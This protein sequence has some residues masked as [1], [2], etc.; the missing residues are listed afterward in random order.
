MSPPEPAG[1]GGGGVRDVATAKH[2]ATPFRVEVPE[3]DLVDLH[4]RLDATRWPDPSVGA[5][6]AQG[7]D[8]QYLRGLV[9]H[10]RHDFDWRA[11]E[12][13]INSTPMF[14]VETG[15]LRLHCA[16]TD[17]RPPGRPLL[18][19]SGWPSTW[20]EHHLVAPRLAAAGL[21]CVWASLP[22]YGFSERPTQPGMTPRRA[23]ALLVHTM[24]VL[25]HPVFAVHGTDWGMLV[26]T[27]MALDHPRSV[28]AIHLDRVPPLGDDDPR[29][30]SRAARY[31]A[32]ERA[33]QLLNGTR[34]QSL[35]YALNDSPVGL[36]G[37]ILEKWRSWSDCGGDIDRS[38]TRDELLTNISI[39]WFTQTA[40]SAA[41]LYYEMRSRPLL[42]PPGRRIE[43]PAG[44][45]VFPVPRPT[46]RPRRIAERR[47]E[48]RHW[49]A[50]PRG[51][52]FPALEEPD[53]LAASMIEFFRKVGYV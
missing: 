21:T 7:T 25:G 41:R 48:I 37:W 23:A 29:Y 44:F 34:P 52:H 24:R 4:R 22:G 33:Y 14:L 36:A 1:Q 16:V 8:A 18:L 39:Y 17:G 32:A 43:P 53:L 31:V 40:G 9:R 20:F 12:R 13:L 11:Q 6:W 35:A 19:L 27:A 38:F 50:M 49:R 46:R 51:G 3:A 47:F 42:P 30:V 2:S 26:A 10:W 45:T 5:P 28:A 15:E